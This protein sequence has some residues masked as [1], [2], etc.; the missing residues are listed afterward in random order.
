MDSQLLLSHLL[1][2]FIRVGRVGRG[3]DAP[4]YRIFKDHTSSLISL[5]ILNLLPFFG[6]YLLSSLSQTS[7]SQ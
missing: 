2:E 5:K 6:V 1:V 3:I 4:S 7:I